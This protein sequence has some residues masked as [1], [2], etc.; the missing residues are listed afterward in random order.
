MILFIGIIALFSCIY[1]VDAGS[2]ALTETFGA[3]LDSS[4]RCGHDAMLRT[5]TDKQ[6]Q[7]LVLLR[8]HERS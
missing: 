7:K 8:V 6:S 5:S 4:T 1:T 3:A 2:V